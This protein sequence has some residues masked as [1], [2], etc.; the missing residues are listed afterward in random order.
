MMLLLIKL[1]IVINPPKIDKMKILKHHIDALKS[2]DIIFGK[3]N[4]V[5]EIT[6]NEK[7]R[8]DNVLMEDFIKNHNLNA[9][10]PKI[11]NLHMSK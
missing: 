6:R 7:D 5:F 10:Y 9:S 3:F 11:V 4:D 2:D 8:L 1:L